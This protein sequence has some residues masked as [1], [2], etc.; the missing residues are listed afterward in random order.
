MRLRSGVSVFTCLF[1]LLV[2]P[3]QLMAQEEKTA[4]PSNQEAPE[5]QQSPKTV[6]VPPG[7]SEILRRLQARP[8]L[9]DDA[10]QAI[11]SLFMPRTAPRLPLSPAEIARQYSDSVVT[12]FGYDESGGQKGQGS[13]LLIGQ[14]DGALFILTNHHVVDG[15]SAIE[16]VTKDKARFPVSTI[17][18]SSPE[19]DLALLRASITANL[20]VI[21]VYGGS[22]ND[23]VPGDR[24]TAIGNPLGLERTVSEGLVS[25]IRK[26][27][28]A[29]FI[30]TTAPISRG[31]SGGPL[32][33][34][35]GEL[36]GLTTLIIQG[37]QNLNIAVAIDHVVDLDD[38]GSVALKTPGG[39]SALD[40]T[41]GPS[42]LVLFG[43][44]PWLATG[45]VFG[46]L[47]RAIAKR[48]GRRPWLWFAAGF[49]PGWNL[50]GAFWLVSLTD[51][52]VVEQ[53]NAILK[54]LRNTWTCPSCGNVNTIEVLTC[55]RCG[56]SP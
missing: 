42:Q 13:G 48:K 53:M 14:I 11:E 6:V 20:R 10:E 12:I 41:A 46:L 51:S 43:L 26:V 1:V 44:I 36:V 8:D 54:G 37:G 40:R 21:K 15:A 22:A 9:S 17:E 4:P 39:M 5:A 56:A 52:A 23:L 25:A 7:V 27:K 19:I 24:V 47:L 16:V 2:L 29:T 35:F 18:A 3:P 38:S 28:G 31:S 32:F 55:L 30:Q 34:A 50:L 49:V 33:N 45:L